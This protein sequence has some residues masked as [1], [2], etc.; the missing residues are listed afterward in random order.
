[1]LH[2]DQRYKGYSTI[3]S[4]LK[5]DSTNALYSC[6]I[7][8]FILIFPQVSRGLLTS[9]TVVALLGFPSLVKNLHLQASGHKPALV[10][11]ICLKNIMCK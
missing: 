2:D 8:F 10:S 11:Y 6:I 4:Y 9:V 1:M 3:M 5:V 7:F